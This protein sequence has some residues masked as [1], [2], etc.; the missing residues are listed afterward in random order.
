MNDWY[1]FDIHGAATMRVEKSA[2]TSA[3][4]RDMFEP[5]L[6]ADSGD[7]DLT[8]STRREPMLN[9][10][11]ADTD[12]RYTSTAI[13]FAQTGVQIVVDGDGY[14]VSGSRELLVVV[15]PLLDRILVRRGIAMLHAAT[16]VWG[17]RGVIMPAWGG[18]GKTS[19]IAKLMRRDDVAFLGDD[20]TFLGQ[21]GRLLGYAKPMTIKPH[22][23][24]I[25][26]HL[27]GSKR[28]PLVPTRLS[29]P[30][31]RLTSA[32][33][34]FMT[35]H[36]ELARI[37]RRY[38]PEHHTVTA[39]VAFPTGKMATEAP[40]G[41][42]VFVERY[43]AHTTVL[44]EMDTESMTARLTGN[45]FAE[46][47]EPSKEIIAALGATGMVPLGAAFAEKA[48]IIA[49]GLGGLP[50]RLMRVPRDIDA[51]QASDI[52]VEHLA[53]VMEAVHV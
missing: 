49:S 40:L 1:A 17:G 30:F 37:A 2:P 42:A 27:F 11:D 36:P 48:A 21:D 14:R 25:Y 19:T 45:F 52:I 23:R 9:A 18:T 10:S 50:C 39:K 7:A 41:A 22:H 46:A 43:E 26:P 24:N 20:W 6:C 38:S 4:L 5:F 35:Q 53:K 33:H 31:G 8:V 32:V 51:D 34:P 28:K 47:P 44:D 29:R 3:L 13:E 16:F 15:L 12:Y